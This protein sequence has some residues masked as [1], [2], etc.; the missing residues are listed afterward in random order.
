MDVKL[1]TQ[2][3]SSAKQDAPVNRDNTQHV[4]AT[5][6]KKFLEDKNVGDLLNNV[7]D[8]NWIQTQK[9]EQRKVG[10]SELGKDAFMSLLLTQMK[11]QDPTTPLK[12][13]EMAA[14]LAQFTSLEKLANIDKGI[15]GLTKAQAPSH[16]FEALSL[17]GKVI[18][19]DSSK[20]NHTTRDQ[21]HDITFQLPK[22][23]SEV[24]LVIK[25]EQG[26]AIRTLK[27]GNLKAGKNE[28]AWN[29]QMEDGTPAQPGNYNVSF[30]AKS[31][32]GDK[33][34][35]QSKLEGKITGINFTAQ[36]PQ[37]MVG[38]QTVEMSEIKT[39]SE[40]APQ[41][42]EQ[43]LGAAA[44]AATMVQPPQAQNN[45]N[46]QKKV[47][48]KKETKDNGKDGVTNAKL[49]GGSLDNTNMAPQLLSQLGKQSLMSGM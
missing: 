23:V 47:E 37:L 35:V 39:I 41:S 17:I 7:A 25:D 13:H 3:W 15:E 43:Q 42:V 16:N 49:S 5:D 28:L 20:V 9:A 32:S 48:V 11:N 38:K 12:S 45:Q 29:G 2:T 21:S 34:F 10:S 19:T 6:Q 44:S 1:N 33:V 46:A 40:S 22:D 8:P 31:S 4:S 36:G 18:T 14:Q 26:N 27:A 24:Q 30:Q